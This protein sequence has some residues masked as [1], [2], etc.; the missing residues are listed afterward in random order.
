M[1]TIDEKY[2]SLREHSDF[3]GARDQIGRS[4]ENAYQHKCI[5]SVPAYLT[6]AEF[7]VHARQAVNKF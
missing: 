4:P 7:E 5:H 3:E 1:L 6:R 2:V